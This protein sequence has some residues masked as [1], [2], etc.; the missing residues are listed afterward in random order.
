[1][2]KTK[3]QTKITDSNS[4]RNGHKHKKHFRKSIRFCG[5]LQTAD[6]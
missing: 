2:N 4:N 1:M 3:I 6:T 5:K